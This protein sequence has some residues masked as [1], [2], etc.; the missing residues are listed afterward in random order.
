VRR[1][2]RPAGRPAAPYGYAWHHIVYQQTVR[3]HGGNLDDPRN[4]VLVRNDAHEHH[5]KRSRVILLAALPDAAYEYAAELLGRGKAY[6]YLRRHYAVGPPPQRR[7][8]PR[9]AALL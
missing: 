8:D 9:L 1:P 5:H 2:A 3:R 7:E 4:L 6:N